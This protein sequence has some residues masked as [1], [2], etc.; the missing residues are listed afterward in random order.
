MA[1]VQKDILLDVSEIKER[2]AT[3]KNRILY[4][5]IMILLK[6]IPRI[7]H[8]AVLLSF[9][10][11]ALQA[12]VKFGDN[13]TVIGT[14]SLLE[15]ES[16]NKALVLPR[17]ADVTAITA[18]IDGMII[19]DLSKDC[20]RS[21]EDGAWSECFTSQET[22]VDNLDIIYSGVK[23]RF[24]GDGIH[25]FIYMPIVGEDGRVWLNNNLGANYAN[26]NLPVFNPKKQAESA[27]DYNAYGS[28]HQWL[29]YSDGH[30]LITWT[31]AT[32]GTPV[33]GTTTVLADDPANPL[34]IIT[35]ASPHDW[36]VNRFPTNSDAFLLGQL[37][38]GIR[39]N[40]PA[41]YALPTAAELSNYITA[42]GITNSAT[43]AN[44]DL[45]LTVPGRRLSSGLADIGTSG[46][47]WTRT[48]N[49]F[50]TPNATATRV[51]IYETAVASVSANRSFGYS[52][53]CIKY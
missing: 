37:N 39:G 34:F 19:F 16:T 18:P 43:A 47:Y 9:M 28:L 38:N 17:I 24:Y 15:L 6:P 52:T 7:F 20:V 45:K 33:N 11:T 26:R 21:Y 53:R 3:N 32:T 46:Y 41:G 30:E 42:A 35:S 4:N 49:G 44:S 22:R 23:D 14:S 31:S 50:G 36:R 5:I 1:T 10:N 51:R 12:Q 25:D 13:P 2:S 8:L 29:R 40:C 48:N 27:D